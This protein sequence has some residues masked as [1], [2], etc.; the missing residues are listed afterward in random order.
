MSAVAARLERIR[1][2]GGISGREVAQLLNTTPQTVSRWKQGRASPQPDRLDR[3]LWLDWIADQLHEVYEPEEAR[4][5]LFAPHPELDGKRPADLIA[6]NQT[7][8]VLAIIDRLRSGA[9]V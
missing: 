7:D 8:E 2:R 6:A 1:R 9:Y 5:W 4:L 3:L